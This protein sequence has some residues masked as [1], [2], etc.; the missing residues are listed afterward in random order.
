[1]AFRVI[2]SC[3][4]IVT[5]QHFGGKYCVH[6]QVKNVSYSK[7]KNEEFTIEAANFPEY[8]GIWSGC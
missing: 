1:M 2:T 3:N 8:L 4:M 7:V 5:C 6:A